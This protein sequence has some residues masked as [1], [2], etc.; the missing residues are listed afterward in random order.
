MCDLFGMLRQLGTPTWFCSFSA[1]DRRWP[2]VCEAICKQQGKEIP[3]NMDW[4]THCC[5]IN[6]NPMAT[7]RMF[8]HRVINFISSV[9]LSPANPIGCVTD[10]FYRTE[11]QSRGWPHIHC[12][13]WCANA[14]KFEAHE[15]NKPLT[16]SID[17]YVTAE[18]PATGSA[19]HDVVADVQLHIKDIQNHV[20]N[21]LKFAG[22]IFQDRHQ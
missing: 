10:Y 1:A 18:L 19:L 2:E 12:L 20:R 6:S 9:I 15:D 21:N 16:E 11:F 22:S 4:S 5:I 13:F 17:E 14:P 7:C 8:E 3:E